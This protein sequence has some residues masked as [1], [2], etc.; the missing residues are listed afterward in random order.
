MEQDA[1]FDPSKSSQEGVL[2]PYTPPNSPGA[3]S[4][5]V[6]T[7]LQPEFP[8]SPSAYTVDTESKPEKR[9]SDFQDVLTK[10]EEISRSDVGTKRITDRMS[11][12]ESSISEKQ[13]KSHF[14]ITTGSST[15]AS[16]ASI[17]HSTVRQPVAHQDT[18]T[19]S[20]DYE[21]SSHQGRRTS[22]SSSE[23]EVVPSAPPAEKKKKSPVAILNFSAI[24]TDSDECAQQPEPSPL[25]KAQFDAFVKPAIDEIED[26]CEPY[27]HKPIPKTKEDNN[28]NSAE[29]FTRQLKGDIFDT[30]LHEDSQMSKD[31]DSQMSE[32][33]IE[34]T[35]ETAHKKAGDYVESMKE[36]EQKFNQSLLHSVGKSE[37]DTTDIE[38]DKLG[39][40]HAEIPKKK[41]SFDE[42]LAPVM[43]AE[44]KTIEEPDWEIVEVEQANDTFS[45][46][47]LHIVIHKGSELENKDYIGKSDPYV[48][49]VYNQQK[50]KSNTIG[51]TLEPE[52][53]YSFDIDVTEDDGKPILVEVFDGDYNQD[54]S[55]GSVSLEI[56]DLMRNQDK[57]WFDLT[58]CK[59]GKIQLSTTFESKSTEPEKPDSKLAT[60]SESL[61]KESEIN[62]HK[63]EF[64]DS[65]SYDEIIDQNGDEGEQK[66]KAMTPE[67]ALEL[68]TEIV[69]NVQTEAIKKYEEI[70]LTQAQSLPKPIAGS[71]FTHQTK[72]KVQEYLKEMEDSEAY[73]QVASELIQKVVTKKE[74]KLKRGNKLEMAVDITEEEPRSDAMLNELRNELRRN[75]ISITDEDLK[76][77]FNSDLLEE[78]AGLARHIEEVRSSL[79]AASDGIKQFSQIEK[80]RSNTDFQFSAQILEQMDQKVPTD[81]RFQTS[82]RS[83]FVQDNSIPESGIT[84]RMSTLMHLETRSESSYSRSGGS[85]DSTKET[86]RKESSSSFFQSNGCP[87]EN[88]P[89]NEDIWAEE[90]KVVFR[91]DFKGIRD[92][93]SDTE[94]T[95]SGSRQN[96]RSLA[97]RKSGTDHDGSGWSSSTETSYLTAE[98]KTKTTSSHSRP[99]SSDV[100]AM[101]SAVSEISSTSGTD[102]YKTAQDISTVESSVYHTAG[103]SISSRESVQS[104][105]SSGNLA[106]FEVSECSETLVE[107]SLE[108][109]PHRSDTPS[110]GGPLDEIS[111]DATN[112]RQHLPAF[113]QKDGSPTTSTDDISSDVKASSPK[114]KEINV[115]S[116]QQIPLTPEE[117]QLLE[118]DDIDGNCLKGQ[119][120]DQYDEEREFLISESKETLASRFSESRE[121]LSSSVLTLSSMSEATIVQRETKE[122]EPPSL[123]SEIG[124]TLDLE[125]K[126]DSLNTSLINQLT[127][128]TSSTSTSGLATHSTPNTDMG[129]LQSS[130]E[131][132]KGP[133][134][135]DEDQVFPLPR[136][137]SFEGTQSVHFSVPQQMSLDFGS[138]YDSRPVSELGDHSRPHSKG[139]RAM[140]G[141]SSNEGAVTEDMPRC[142]SVED[143]MSDCLK[144]T[145]PY[146]RPVSPLPDSARP[147]FVQQM[148]GFGDG[149]KPMEHVAAPVSL[150]SSEHRELQSVESIEA[151]IAFSKHFTQVLDETD[152]FETN[153]I[154]KTNEKMDLTPESIGTSDS[155]ETSQGQEYLIDDDSLENKPSPLQPHFDIEDQDD[156]LV[157]S[158]P[159][160]SR[161]LGVKYWPPLDNLDQELDSRGPEDKR[162]ITRSESDDNSESRLDLDNDLIEKE[163]E[164]GKRWLEN[165]FDGPV[166]P[167]EDP[168]FYGYGQPLDQILEEEE[169]RES[170]SSIDNQELMRLKESLSSTPDFDVIINKRHLVSK[171][172]ENDDVSLGSLTEFERLESEVALGSGTLSRGSI[173]SND[174]LE[175]YG[176]GNGKASNLVAAKTALKPEGDNVSVLSFEMMEK[177]CDDADN[178]EKKAKEQEE[179]L[180]EIEEG[181]ES[182]V[183]ESDETVSECEPKSDDEYEDRMFKIDEIIRQAQSNVE[184]FEQSKPAKNEISLADIMG[185]PD[186]RTE[187]VGHCSGDNDSL[188]G[189]TVPELPKERELPRQSSMPSK[190]QFNTA[191]RT[192]SVTSLH[193]MASITSVSTLTQFDE[194]SIRDRDLEID[195]IMQASADSL[196]LKVK[197]PDNTMITSTDSLE[198]TRTVDKM[199]FS[200]DSIDNGTST[201]K[202]NDVMTVSIDS[203]D[204]SKNGTWEK[205]MSMTRGPFDDVDGATA[206]LHTSTDSF[207]SSS[208][209]TRATASMLSSITS[210]TSQGS[211]TLVADDEFEFDNDD[212]INARRYLLNQGNI[213]IEDSDDSVSHSSPI[214]QATYSQDF[215]QEEILETHEIDS[216]GNRVVKKLIQ[217]RIDI[218]NQPNTVKF[219]DRKVETYLRD[220]SEKRD[221]SCEETIEEIDEFGNKRKF[222][223]KRSI[224]PATTFETLDVVQDRRQQRGLSPIGDVFRSIVEDQPQS[225][226]EKRQ[227]IHHTET[228]TKVFDAP[229]STPS[230]PSSPLSSSFRVSPPTFKKY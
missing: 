61:F 114:S 139:E 24:G 106:S 184:N 179:V 162:S 27:E 59:S 219:T 95:S 37:E 126:C 145:E 85:I 10:F 18:I 230:P 43:Q 9:K 35:L 41:D 71:K 82:F 160:V 93:K 46:G 130:T 128:S 44:V 8:S 200:T 80:D 187:S 67:K 56:G 36:I 109:D 177:A 150:I 207:E 6:D 163:V 171:S 81:F 154:I 120:K 151:E 165:Q 167:Q 32:S 173:G 195:D 101:L 112:Q 11:S 70:L 146:V 152:V 73:D 122:W 170:H 198:A 2:L 147:N 19:D 83:H 5:S 142:H 49:A 100:D 86:S 224:E 188:D 140:S 3:P 4:H 21:S 104:S 180:S 136:M 119:S 45:P 216:S 137:R 12:T 134:T 201:S 186:S 98:E 90:S 26:V 138:E 225:L 72:E 211:E 22:T 158:P 110:S 66:K 227:P 62:K 25:Q 33:T 1:K 54:D 92:K 38:Y 118:E 144:V 148:S 65:S 89:M 133:I 48:T 199:T 96:L 102:T 60:A 125:K 202:N 91:K 228:M 47:I 141:S 117:I 99:S 156:L 75:S 166:A 127:D 34:N 30:V 209:N 213:P 169:D 123:S 87:Q 192:T 222:I 218:P 121:T 143:R 215:S 124:S 196:D 210:M 175:M 29:L 17:S 97:D 31:E 220:L 53:N 108:F 68:A 191:S 190:L 135:N 226:L 64:K 78:H 84:E 129:E 153:D 58:K 116:E 205:S 57:K 88:Q 208:T 77:D 203:L 131:E 52:W 212:S 197:S 103:S 185:Q 189:E 221:D 176:N 107:S 79:G 164:E 40:Y 223:V 50:F 94:S 229:P 39:Q 214:T 204:G 182:Q 7:N 194:A 168:N 74:E 111:F 161:P 55:I 69:Q 181:H 20:S 113:V 157:G 159:M 206:V 76:C 172:A 132:I 193:S 174:S 13:I 183:S 105:E 63:I 115:D 149:L 155:I 42:P 217:K 23:L 28:I 14:K 15:D 51:N 16:S 178:I